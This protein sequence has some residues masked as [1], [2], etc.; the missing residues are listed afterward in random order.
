MVNFKKKL[1]S[2]KVVLSNPIEIYDSLDRQSEK[3][4]LRPVQIEILNKWNKLY[5]EEKNTILKLHT[6]Q[7]K[8]IVGLLILQ[9]NLNLG[10]GPSLYLCPN[11]QLVEQT[12]SQA[13][14]FGI[15][16]CTIGSD[17]C[18]PEDFTNE[19]SIL[20][21]HVQKLFNGMTV[22]GLGPR[23]TKIGTLILDDSH[24]CINVIKDAFRITVPSDKPLYNELLELFSEELP[25]QGLGS[26]ADIKKKDYDA[27]LKVP[28]WVW[29]N[30]CE[31]ISAILSRYTTSNA[32]KFTWPL[33]KDYLENCQCVISGNRLEISPYLEPLDHFS[34][35][36]KADHRI[37][38]SATV[39]DDAF[40]IKSM[41]LQKETV[42]NPLVIDD[43]KWSGEKMVLIPS[44]IDSSLTREEIVNIFAKPSEKRKSGIV[45]LVPSF[46][47]SKD[48]ESY[49]SKVAK[50]EDI[51]DSIE[52]LKNKEC[53]ET[54]VIVNRYDGIDLPDNACRVLII[55]SLP[56][57][58]NLEDLY[59]SNCVGES[60]TINSRLS[61]VIEQ[62]L[63]RG[64]R[65]EK[66]YCVVVI[67]GS[68]LVRMLRNRKLR[69]YFS[70]QTNL[71][72]ELGEEIAEFAKEEIEAG[73]PPMDAF[74]ELLVQSLKRD[75]GW[76][77]F[78]AEKMDSLKEKTINQNLL[79]I[80]SLEYQ[81]EK[82]YLENDAKCLEI[83]DELVE[84]YS[85]SSE[86]KGW[87]LQEKARYASKFSVSLSKDIQ[88]EAYSV[89][90]FLLKPDNAPITNPL[91][92][93]SI[94]RTTKV[95]EWIKNFKEY[96]EMYLEVESIIENLQFGVNADKFEKALNQ[97]GTILGFSC[98]RPDKESKQGPD[99]L[100]KLDSKSYVL[101]ECKNNVKLDRDEIKKSET[102]QM[103]NSC[104]WFNRHFPGSNV[105]NIM[106]ISSRI[107]EASAG[108]NEE[109]VIMK[110]AK[111]KKLLSNVKKFFEEFSRYNLGDIS[112]EK[113]QE[114]INF[115]QLSVQNILSD[116][117]CEAP[118]FKN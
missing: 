1:S 63:G 50:S 4:P 17:N 81:A 86:E 39:N 69:E 16:Y 32:L 73:K 102:G 28:Y 72:I 99:N 64:V 83:I 53:K 111:L 26:Y 114:L 65:G 101:F 76:K 46:N 104:A 21:T 23:S 71:Q 91:V 100:W 118:Y 38:M 74:N 19:K 59:K 60:I 93:V 35:F 79:D 103:N 29:Q 49:G 12:C 15:K 20:I 6:G 70:N 77:E 106:I 13:E 84:K 43:E 55:D 66:D 24:A 109:V 56:Y 51:T 94:K 31:E 61:Q 9:T 113:V 85:P 37:F 96:K 67:I 10:K 89:N 58:E 18:L 108:F 92:N 88:K 97:L 90:K 34:T 87:Y 33:L 75:E 78:Y 30:K 82:A 52:K 80:Y 3:G 5:K 47:R 36:T 54:L 11:K 48:W 44:L 8:T 62:G 112:D 41:G 116:D 68:E 115:H 40:F 7:G 14:S 57:L 22:F 27:F 42:I 45:T 25:K 107:V 2:T 105:K 117:Y 98:S 95:K 110:K